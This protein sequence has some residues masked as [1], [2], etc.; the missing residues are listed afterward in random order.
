MQGKTLKSFS[1]T[2]LETT[3][4]K[5]IHP[6]LYTQMLNW[7][8]QIGAVSKIS[9]SSMSHMSHVQGTLD[10]MLR[11]HQLL[12]AAAAKVSWHAHVRD[13]PIRPAV[14]CYSP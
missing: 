1:G 2:P 13:L 5:F 10:D 11:Q 8:A 4:R 12:L 3:K 6:V 9:T 7:V 14:K